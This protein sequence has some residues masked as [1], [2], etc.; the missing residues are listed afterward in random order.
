[1]SNQQHLVFAV[2]KAARLPGFLARTFAVYQE[3][4]HLTED[5]LRG[6]LGCSMPDFIHLAL[7]RVSPQPATDELRRLAEFADA[8]LNA[9]AGIIRRVN[10]IEALRDASNVAVPAVLLAA[11][12]REDD[13]KKSRNDDESTG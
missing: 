9:L 7:C 8:D 11:R 6:L 12:E 5:E 10:A 1:M 2:S 13:V 4:E 3:L